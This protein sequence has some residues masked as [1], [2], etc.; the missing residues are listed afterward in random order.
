[1]PRPIQSSALVFPN[2]EGKRDLRWAEKTFPAAVQAAKIE[3][4][5]LH[6]TRHTFAS[7]L[8][9]EGVDLLTIK[10]LGGWKDVKMVQRYAHLSPGHRQQA[11]ERLATR[12]SAAPSLSMIGE[13]PTPQ[14]LV[15]KRVGR[16]ERYE[17][18][19]DDDG[20]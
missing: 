15:C 20:T 2:T 16:E 9:M 14:K 1:M 8:A 7:R 3:N 4:F 19:K 6:D 18:G 13:T 11:I 10:E 5:R 12:P 17:Q